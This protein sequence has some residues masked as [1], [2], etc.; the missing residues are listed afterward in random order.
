MFGM[1]LNCLFTS[2]KHCFTEHG[3]YLAILNEP[4]RTS[5]EIETIICLYFREKHN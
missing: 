3:E 4:N 5:I 1:S 2:E